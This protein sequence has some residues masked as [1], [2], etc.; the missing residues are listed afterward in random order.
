MTLCQSLYLSISMYI[1]STLTKILQLKNDVST[2]APTASFPTSGIR[3]SEVLQP[4]ATRHQLVYNILDS[5]SLKN[6]EEKDAYEVAP[7][8]VKSLLK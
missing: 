7:H 4:V 3:M 2:S 6:R 1:G 8:R 5:V